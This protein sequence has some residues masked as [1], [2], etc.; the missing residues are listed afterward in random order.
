MARIIIAD[1]DEI[2]GSIAR[3]ALI[4]AGH[5]AGLVTDGAEALR[6]IKA[7]R[8]DLVILDCNMPGLSG[9]LLVQELRKLNDFA[10]LPVM[11][12]TGRRSSRDEEL[13]RFAGAN[14][15]MKKP[16]DPDELVFRVN[17]MLAKG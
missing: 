13:A 11:M 5:G 4:A 6:V 3:D 16:F 8:P 15:Y 2:L 14:E 1:D 12:L 7:R 10:L 17:E 9:V